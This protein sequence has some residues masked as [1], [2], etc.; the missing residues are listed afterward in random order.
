MPDK[1]HFSPRTRVSNLPN[2]LHHAL[3]TYLASPAY[4]RADLL[5]KVELVCSFMAQRIADAI[6]ADQPGSYAM[7]WQVRAAARVASL[8]CGS[9]FFWLLTMRNIPQA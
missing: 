9:P 4:P 7:D 1:L 2:N 3:V 8:L 5:E 6:R